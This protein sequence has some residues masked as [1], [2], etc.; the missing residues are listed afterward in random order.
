MDEVLSLDP[1]TAPSMYSDEVL[2]MDP[3]ECA[4]LHPD[5]VQSGSR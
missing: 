2:I 4:S 1:E 5:E 3:D